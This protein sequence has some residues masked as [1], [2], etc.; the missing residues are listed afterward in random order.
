MT[1]LPYPIRRAGVEDA[2]IIAEVHQ[3]SREAL[4][5]G[6]IPDSLIDALSPAERVERWRSF[7][8]DPGVVTLVGEEDGRM[9]GFCTLRAV[10]DDDLRGDSVGEMPTLYLHP[11]FWRQGWGTALCNAIEARAAAMG[12]HTLVLWVLD[13]NERARAFY[14]ARGFVEDGARKFDDPPEAA[15]LPA[16]RHRKSLR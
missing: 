15:D 9:V 1:T 8:G 2:P 10:V 6:R 12:Y 5:R 16:L 3:A 7:L 11:D 4:Y 14:R 13:M